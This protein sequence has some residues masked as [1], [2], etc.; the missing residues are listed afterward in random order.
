MPTPARINSPCCDSESAA[1][2]FL[3]DIAL[4]YALVLTLE[5]QLFNSKSNKSS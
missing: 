5:G 2:Q 3:N 1:V 4:L